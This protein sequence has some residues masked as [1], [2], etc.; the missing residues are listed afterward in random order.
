MRGIVYK[1]TNKNNGKV[2]IGQTIRE[3][4][5][6]E[7]HRR[8]DSPSRFHSAIKKYGW[9]N[10]EYAVIFTIEHDDIDI[11]HQLLDSIEVKCIDLC[12][13]TNPHKG[14]NMSRG[15]KGC[16]GYRLSD[17]QR[18]E[19]SKKLKGRKLDED[20]RQKISDTRKARKHPSP[21]KGKTLSEDTKKKIRRNSTNSKPFYVDGIEYPSLREAC[22]V[23]GWEANNVQPGKCKTYRGHKISRTKS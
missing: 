22:R 13:S 10:F 3:D 7:Q 16:S 5:R 23:F 17:K 20:W 19:I 6:M 18:E 15:G 9:D 11:I 4:I 1:Y 12:D 21:N 2:Y 8:C 14:Y